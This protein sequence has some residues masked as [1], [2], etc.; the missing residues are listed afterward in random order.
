MNTRP[1]HDALFPL[2]TQKKEGHLFRGPPLA[3]KQGER[4][5]PST[6]PEVYYSF[7]HRAVQLNG[8]EAPPFGPGLVI[9]TCPP[10]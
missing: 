8:C 2:E 5:I 6:L 1:A 7:G 10:C 9:T 4:V 3:R